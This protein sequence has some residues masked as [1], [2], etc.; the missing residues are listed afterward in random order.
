MLELRGHIRRFDS[1]TFKVYLNEWKDGY[2]M[3]LG[4]FKTASQHCQ[5]GDYVSIFL[6]ENDV[7]HSV[8][9]RQDGTD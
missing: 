5:P 9:R 1:A 3:T 2:V 7:V 8:V 4:L 6:D